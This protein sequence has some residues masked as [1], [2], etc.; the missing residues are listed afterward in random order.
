MAKIPDPRGV[1]SVEVGA[2]V[3]R[4][5]AQANG[6]LALGAVASACAMLPGK[7]HRYL[8]SLIA[9][10]LVVQDSL[11]KLYDLG[12]FAYMLGAAALQRYDVVRAASARLD[13]LRVV[14]GESA[15]LMIW[16]ESRGVVVRSEVSDHD[17]AMVLRVGASV[18]LITSAAGRIFA[19]FLPSI[20]TE[21]VLDA[22]FAERTVLG[23]KPILRTAYAA[24]LDEVRKR[25]TSVIHDGPV[26]GA[27]AIAAPLFGP[28]GRLL[29]V[30]SVVG[31][32]ATLE[33]TRGGPVERELLAFCRRVEREP[34]Q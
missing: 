28:E 30:V 29:A 17:V 7:T 2:G 32:S 34:S 14:C 33:V 23:S 27:G 13:E 4:S 22:E 24:I 19:A 20:V 12:P 16:G 6:P 18:R 31:R 3:L 15:S 26:D 25:G 10:G 5:L 9:A 1:N 11:T 8:R 21:P